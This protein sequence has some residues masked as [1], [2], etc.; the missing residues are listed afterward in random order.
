MSVS[1]NP[2]CSVLILQHLTSTSSTSIK[3][4]FKT[5]AC[6]VSHDA[7]MLEQTTLCKHTHK[8]IKIWWV[9]TAGHGFRLQCKGHEEWWRKSAGKVWVSG[10]I[11]VLSSEAVFTFSQHRFPSIHLLPIFWIDTLHPQ[12][13]GRRHRSIWVSQHLPSWRQWSLKSPRLQSAF[14]HLL[15]HFSHFLYCGM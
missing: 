14:F 5:Q 4:Y 1:L 13:S 15:S 8:P 2:S 3:K 9:K 7:R 6:I 12:R 11:S 10:V